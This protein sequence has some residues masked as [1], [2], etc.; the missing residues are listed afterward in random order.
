MDRNLLLHI[1]AF[2]TVPVHRKHFRFAVTSPGGQNDVAWQL[3][4]CQYVNS[5]P[6]PR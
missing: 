4:Q 5:C 2:Q 6:F 3:H 1:Y